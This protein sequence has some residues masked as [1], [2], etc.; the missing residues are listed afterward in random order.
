MGEQERTRKSGKEREALGSEHGNHTFEYD[1][2][3]GTRALGLEPE[4]HVCEYAGKDPWPLAL[5]A[6]T[7]GLNMPIASTSHVHVPP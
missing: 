2:D 6:C 1:V 5:C 7:I 4:G 3:A